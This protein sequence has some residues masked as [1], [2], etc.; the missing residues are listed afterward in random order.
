MSTILDYH[1]TELEIAR[2]PSDPRHCAPPPMKQGTRVLDIGCGA[3]QTLITSCTG[4]VCFGVDLDTAALK[5]GEILAPGVHFA[6]AKAEALPFSDQTFDY[7]LARNCLQYTDLASSI[8]D[9][10][11]VLNTGGRVWV[12][13]LSW[14]GLRRR[15][16]NPNL[17]QLIFGGYIVLNSLALWLTGASFPYLNGMREVLHAKRTLRRA[18]TRAGFQDV[19]ISTGG[20]LIATASKP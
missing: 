8:A 4:Q 1:L 18:L 10:Y 14:H 9:I 3:G 5:L 16:R 17:K 13:V 11:R 19:G 15:M 20:H 6:R 7:V 2:N 12:V